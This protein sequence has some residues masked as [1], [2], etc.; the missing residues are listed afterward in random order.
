[1]SNVL[2]E[3]L[4]FLLELPLRRVRRRMW[5]FSSRA[6]QPAAPRETCG[7]TSVASVAAHKGINSKGNTIGVRIHRQEGT[8]ARAI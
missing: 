3:Q 6:C 7:S 4:F 2:N 5:N 8:M 1:M